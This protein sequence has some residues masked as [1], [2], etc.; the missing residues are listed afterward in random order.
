LN[1]IQAELPKT[2]ILRLAFRYSRLQGFETSKKLAK[3]QPGYH[4]LMGSRSAER[5]Q[6]A[7]SKLQAE[8]L[9]VEPITLDVTSDDSITAAFET[10][11]SK[12][13]RLDVLIN[14]AGIAIDHEYQPGKTSVRETLYKNYN[15]NVF[16]AIQV[17]E[18]FIPLLEKASVPR[19][20]F[21]SSSL[22]SL[23]LA[24]A[25]QANVP[26]GFPIYRSTK[27]ALNMLALTYAVKYEPKG[28]KI[29]ACCPGYLATNLNNYHGTGPVS[30][31][32]INAA[33]LATLGKDGETGTYSNKEGPLP[34]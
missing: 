27:T 31:G 14:N 12:Y 21:I 3:E 20:V 8:G 9:S 18:T 25:D 5:G 11:S 30:N 16:G 34:W 19:V 15:T 23:E 22:A 17:L 26:G 24:K 33:H 29:N 13:G 1:H 2:P 32:A 4:I 10:I 6:E 28:W 7:A